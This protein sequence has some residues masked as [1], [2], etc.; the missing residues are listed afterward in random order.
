M[1]V[2]IRPYT[3]AE[4]DAALA[5][6]IAAFTPIHEGFRAALGERV[7]D[8]AARHGATARPVVSGESYLTKPGELSDIVVA[9]VE[10]VTGITPELSTSGGT[11]DARFLKDLCPVIDFGPPNATMHKRDEAVAVDDLAA[12]SRIYKRIVEAALDRGNA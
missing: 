2:T 12:L 9:A 7:S 11:S 5:I 8:I 1:T 3:Q 4:R 10:A 6:C